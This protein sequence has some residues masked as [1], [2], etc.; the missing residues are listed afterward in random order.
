[1]ITSSPAEDSE[2]AGGALR[3]V[4]LRPFSASS[5]VQ[6]GPVTK[7]TFLIPEL[8]EEKRRAPEDSHCNFLGEQRSPR[9]C[10]RGVMS[11]PQ[12]VSSSVALR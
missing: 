12:G 3:S 9:I 1:M 11:L 6:E 8:T 7:R 2:K 5:V 10:L 4:V